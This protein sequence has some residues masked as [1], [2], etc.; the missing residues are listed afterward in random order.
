M[1]TDKS[2]TPCSDHTEVAEEQQQ[3]T[4]Q[5]YTEFL[6]LIGHKDLTHNSYTKVNDSTQGIW[7]SKVFVPL[8]PGGQCR[9]EYT[10]S[11]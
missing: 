10:I 4:L 8:K 7:Y 11:Y 1:N 6:K 2:M 9:C 3:L 5:K